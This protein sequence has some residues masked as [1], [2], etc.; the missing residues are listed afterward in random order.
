MALDQS[1][2]ITVA[3]GLDRQASADLQAEALARAQ[4]SEASSLVWD[5]D[6]GK[7]FL[8]H[9]TLLDNTSTRFPIK[10]TSSA[11][12]P[13]RI[14]VYAPE[15]DGET[16]VLELALSTRILTIY[17][18]PIVALP[19]LYTLDTLITALL[20]LLLHLHRSSSTSSC[21]Q[22]R[23]DI[24]PPSFPPPPSVLSASSRTAHKKKRTLSTWTKSVF[25]PS[26][27]HLP[28]DEE[29]GLVH[30]EPNGV[31]PSQTKA[32][33]SEWGFKP[34]IDSEDEKLPTPT[35]AALRGLYWGFEVIV[36]ILGVLVNLIA[37]G[38]VGAGKLLK[39]L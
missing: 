37:G 14:V 12:N 23:N 29:S 25:A 21:A 30:S 39:K 19:S 2:T 4:K 35:R 17:T 38:I 7:Y 36:W 18:T 15:T 3:H 28:Q 11:S 32:L 5:S 27:S 20:M 13:K 6:C 8:I 26:T 1:S 16:P 24:T 34:M 31:V 10:I 33:E 9:P 22:P